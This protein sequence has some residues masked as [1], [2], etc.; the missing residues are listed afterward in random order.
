MA[1]FCMQSLGCEVDAI[2]TVNYSRYST[3]A[4]AMSAANVL[5]KAIMSATDDSMAAKHQ[6]ARLRISGRLSR[7]PG[8]ITSI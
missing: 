5:R 1:T 6:P 7:M 8:W 3:H 2:H 4:V